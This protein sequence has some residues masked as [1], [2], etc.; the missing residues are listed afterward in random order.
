NESAI[1]LDSWKI[2]QRT[3]LTIAPSPLLIYANALIVLVLG[4]TDA[5]VRLLPMV[6]GCLVALSPLAFRSRIGR[7]GALIAGITLATSPTLIVAS[8]QVDSTMISLALAIA[9][10]ILVTS[11][12]PGRAPNRLYLAAGV[13]ALLLMSGPTAFS[14]LIILGGFALVVSRRGAEAGKDVRGQWWGSA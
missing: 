6:A 12:E 10:V 1:A 3:G 14:L 5:T 11:G 7:L 9:L 4:A 8:R 13:L 2:V